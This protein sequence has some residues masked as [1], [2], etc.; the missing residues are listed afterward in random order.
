MA[1]EF[2]FK[3]TMEFAYGQPRELAPGIIRLVANNPNPFTFKGSNTYLVGATDL[4][5]IDPGPDDPAHFDA[6]MSAVGPRRRIT[7]LL[8]THSHRDHTAGLER[9]RQAT[10]AKACG[11]GRSPR[12]PGQL[13]ASPS[14][15]EFID[16]NFR[17][18]IVLRD[19]DAVS[20]PDWRLE[21][22]YTPGHAPD[23]L[24]FAL[25][26]PRVLFTGDHVMGW[27]TTVIAPP[28]GNMAD[29]MRSLERLSER[30]D[31][32]FMPGHGG[33]MDQPARWVKAY[34]LHRQWREQAILDA[35]KS[36]HATI[37]QIVSLV[38]GGI[39]DR[40]RDAASLSVLAHVEHLI[41]RGLVRCEG[42]PTFDRRL[43][44]V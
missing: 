25:A 8:I 13:Q 39:A 35:I 37:E 20:G 7:H 41:E 40:L 27:N 1:N 19:G 14:G 5:V 6:I 26:Q 15:S 32:L 11:Y 4:A 24:C 10:G 30:D 42:P 28:E 18:D 29:Y 16:R 33:R 38:Y 44:A 2:A 21:A 43:S 22:I 31:E 9:L 34:L 17:P 23:H 12:A 3:T 36:G